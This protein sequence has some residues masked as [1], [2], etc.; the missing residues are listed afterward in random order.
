MTN[1]CPTLNCPQKQPSKTLEKML[2]ALKDAIETP[3]LDLR[4]RFPVN[5]P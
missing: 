3:I 2:S 4:G 5:C 1:G